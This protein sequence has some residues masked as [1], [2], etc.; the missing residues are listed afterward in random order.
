[1]EEAS[2][3]YRGQDLQAF[4][5]QELCESRGGRPGLPVPNKPSVSVDVK[6]RSTNQLRA[7]AYDVLLWREVPQN[8]AWSVLKAHLPTLANA[9]R[10]SSALLIL[11]PMAA[12]GL[13][14]KVDS[15]NMAPARLQRQRHG[16]NNNKLSMH[17]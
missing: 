6:Q 17:F 9:P 2:L 5:A 4:R 7:L 13:G 1:M 11:S 15:F 10:T 12:A 14:A 8:E 3:V 16:R